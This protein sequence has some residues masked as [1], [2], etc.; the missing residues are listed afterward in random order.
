MFKLH[1]FVNDFPP[2]RY[3]HRWLVTLLKNVILKLKYL[4]SREGEG[5][6][7]SLT[8]FWIELLILKEKHNLDKKQTERIYI[9]SVLSLKNQRVL[10]LCFYS[11]GYYYFS[12]QIS[13]AERP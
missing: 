2:E 4:N 8:I 1:L 5:V 10:V 9:C 12:G 6:S 11:R 13:L 3:I 7:L